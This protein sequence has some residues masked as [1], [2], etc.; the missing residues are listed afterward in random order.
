[1]AATPAPRGARA[2][3]PRASFLTPGTTATKIAAITAAIIAEA[4]CMI[5]F[6]LPR[7]PEKIMTV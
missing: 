5:L 4:L 7:R 1:M 2:C 6:S 3:P